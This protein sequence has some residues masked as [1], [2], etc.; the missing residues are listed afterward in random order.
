MESTSLRVVSIDDQ[1]WVI[2][3]VRRMRAQ[4]AAQEMSLRF[5]NGA[6]SRYVTDYPADWPALP[7]AE[8]TTLFQRAERRA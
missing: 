6:E 7:D 4:C 2:R 8:I 5:F 3:T 1:R